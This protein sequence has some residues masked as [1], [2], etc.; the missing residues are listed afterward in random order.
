MRKIL[1]VIAMLIGLPVAAPAQEV[2][3]NAQFGD[4]IVA[5]EAVST[6]RTSCRIVQSQSIA[7]TGALVAKFVAYPLAEGEALLVAQVPMGVY[8]PGG[9]VFRP[10]DDET[11]EQQSMIWQRCAGAICEAALQLTADNVENLAAA[12]SIIFG[13][14]ANP[15]QDPI[16]TRVSTSAFADALNAIRQE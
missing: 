4:W 1:P 6:Q 13:Y 7:E 12:E 15:G 5:C 11:A 16:V 14:Q 3:N 2:A 10:A 8:L 9:A